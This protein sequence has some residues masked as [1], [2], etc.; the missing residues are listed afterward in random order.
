MST[1]PNGPGQHF[2]CV[3]R[4]WQVLQY[5]VREHE[6]E[7]RLRGDRLQTPVPCEGGIAGW[8]KPGGFPPVV[9]ERIEPG[10]C[11]TSEV[12]YPRSGCGVA[13]R[14]VRVEGRHQGAGGTLLRWRAQR[15]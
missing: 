8:L 5:V 15:R 2:H 1:R 4:P 7:F 11:A 14:E 12:K 6:I 3:E 10:P 9:L 13:G